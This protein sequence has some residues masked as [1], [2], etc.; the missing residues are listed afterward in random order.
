MPRAPGREP[1][2]RCTAARKGPPGGATGAEAGPLDTVD[3][4]P[5]FDRLNPPDHGLKPRGLRRVQT[6]RRSGWYA[7]RAGVGPEGGG[8]APSASRNRLIR[9]SSQ[10]NQIIETTER[11]R[12]V[13]SG[14]TPD[15]PGPP[16][17]NRRTGTNGES[18]IWRESEL[19]RHII[20]S[21]HDVCGRFS[22]HQ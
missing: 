8:V 18:G 22:H 14:L 4:D 10:S 1:P 9:Q 7:T 11:P 21:F 13:D 17:Q 5:G 20:A 3:V 2:R 19:L 6:V 12:S 16:H 15:A